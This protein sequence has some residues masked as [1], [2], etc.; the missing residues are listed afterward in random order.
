M[1][2]HRVVAGQRQDEVGRY[3]ACA[4]VDQLEEAV[5]G[6]GAGLAP[7]HR[8]GIVVD[9]LAVAR[10]ALAIALHIDLLQIGRQV[11]QVLIVGDDRLGVRT[12]E[13]VVPDSE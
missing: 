4:L 10:D 9:R 8:A 6:V 5:L 2:F 13:I 1:T 7:D 3:Q 12:T 11:L